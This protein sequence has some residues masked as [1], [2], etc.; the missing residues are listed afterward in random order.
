MLGRGRDDRMGPGV[1]AEDRAALEVARE[2]SQRILH[3]ADEA[4]R[5]GM[6]EAGRAFVPQGYRGPERRRN[7]R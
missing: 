2:R 1:T 3:R 5:I 6:E 4:I 7:P